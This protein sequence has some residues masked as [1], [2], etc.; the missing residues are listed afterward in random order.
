[1]HLHYDSKQDLTYFNIN[2]EQESGEIFSDIGLPYIN[3]LATLQ[4]MDRWILTK[5]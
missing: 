3:S 1:M 4:L 2:T 5:G